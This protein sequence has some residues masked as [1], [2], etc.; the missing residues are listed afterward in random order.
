MVKRKKNLDENI[1]IDDSQASSE[2]SSHPLDILKVGLAKG[3]ITK[4][5]YEGLRKMVS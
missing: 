3:E 1:G 2:L 5:E 4:A